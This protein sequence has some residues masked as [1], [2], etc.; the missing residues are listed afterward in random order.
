MNGEFFIFI[1]DEENLLCRRCW[2]FYERERNFILPTTEIFQFRYH[3]NIIN[4]IEVTKWK[5]Q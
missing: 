4:K 3:I 5:I 1:L 2:G